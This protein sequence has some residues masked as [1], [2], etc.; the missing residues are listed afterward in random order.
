MFATHRNFLRRTSTTRGAASGR[1]RVPT[2]NAPRP[3]LIWRPFARV[4]LAIAMLAVSCGSPEARLSDRQIAA[5]LGAAGRLLPLYSA[6][7]QLDKR[8]RE[9]AV[10]VLQIG[11]SHTAN[12]A[13]SGR[14]RELFQ[15]RFGDAGRGL[16]P[17][18]IPYRYYKPARVH[19]TAKNWTV[20]SS[21][22]ASAAGPFGVSALRQHADG[23]AEM[24]LTADNRGDLDR[25]AIE[26]LEQPG[27]GTVEVE[28]DNGRHTSF[29]TDATRSTPA[30]FKLSGTG[31]L[32]LILRARGD[33]PVDLLAWSVQRRTPGVI[34]ANLGTIGATI[35]LLGRWDP[36]IV[37]A[38][39][40]RLRPSLIVVAFGTNEAFSSKTDID[41]YPTLYA[42]RVRMLHDAVPG[43]PLLVIG[44]PD[45]NREW[46]PGS[47]D[48]GL[49]GADPNSVRPVLWVEPTNLAAVRDAQRKVADEA[50]FYFWDWSEAMGGRCAMWRWVKDDPTSAAPDHVHLFAPGY[51]T[52][53]ERL[54]NELM[55]GYDR[56]RAL[57]R[58]R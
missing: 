24:T 46:R 38:E 42:E 44:P 5:R 4:L 55:D 12:D 40:A 7:M 26:V 51:R 41:H 25:V 10:V 43:A 58:V 15:A 56:Y 11:D 9:D 49:C 28:F 3:A 23:P 16:L 32:A 57:K 45:G 14:M 35:D 30:W 2:P 27:G 6:L 53:A 21:F 54:F 1:R 50:G 20:V 47:T 13:F 33:G 48:A 22:D 36:E 37:A 34:Y 52:T 17:P 39:M 18:G 29:A 19:V 31:S 8:K